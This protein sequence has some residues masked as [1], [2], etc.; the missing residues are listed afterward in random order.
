MSFRGKYLKIDDFSGGDCSALPDALLGPSQARQM[1]NIFI[2]PEGL[3]FRSRGVT[4]Y[5]NPTEFGSADSYPVIG[6]GMLEASSGTSY[7]LAIKK[8]KAYGATAGDLRT[9]TFVD[10]TGAVSIATAGTTSA[11]RTGYRWSFCQHN[12]LL[13]GFGGPSTAPDAPFKWVGGA[14][15]IAALGGTPP[16]ARFGFSASNRVFAGSTAAD[17]ATLYWS[18]LGNPEDWTGT[19]SGSVVVGNLDDGE[20]IEA[21]CLLRNNL[22]LIFKKNS[23][24][25]VDLSFAPFAPVLLFN[26]VGA[27]GVNSVTVAD[28][29]AY[30]VTPQKKLM[31]T[32][33]NKI[34]PIP[35]NTSNLQRMFY[36][37]PLVFRLRSRKG[38]TFSSAEFDCIVVCGL[39]SGGDGDTVVSSVAW[40]INNECWLYFSTG[41]QFISGAM[42]QSTGYYYGGWSNQGRVFYPEYNMIIS[43]LATDDTGV[44]S[45]AINCFWT[46]GWLKLALVDEITRIMRFGVQTMTTESVSYNATLTYGYDFGSLSKSASLQVSGGAV[47]PIHS[48][49]FLSGRG[50]YFSFKYAF[51]PSTATSQTFVH[52]M[53][54]GGKIPLGAKAAA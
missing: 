54:L 42:K 47:V 48:D 45:G 28:G 4:S 32:D 30:F 26:G 22:A 34:K 39:S 13:I 44:S 33:G 8:G 49:A 14:N 51:T 3:G 17:P 10:R 21:A 37:S 12:D 16:S 40:D 50:K 41:Y 11:E 5:A 31:A 1:D 38:T 2:L 18:T 23:I 43:L 19:G 9:T 7:V 15:N 36:G 6:V 35:T 53:E 27:E 20:P 46:S 29:L 52:S 24:Y 25:Q